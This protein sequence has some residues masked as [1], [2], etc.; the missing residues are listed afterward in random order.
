MSEKTTLR[1]HTHA[2]DSYMYF[3]YTYFNIPNNFKHISPS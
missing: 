2:L 3:L 1:H